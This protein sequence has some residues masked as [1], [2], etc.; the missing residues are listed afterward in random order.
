MELALMTENG[1]LVEMFVNVAEGTP[2][3]GLISAFFFRGAGARMMTRRSESEN[4]TRHVATASQSRLT[5]GPRGWNDRA[6]VAVRQ[7]S[8]SVMFCFGAVQGNRVAR[9]WLLAQ[10]GCRQGDKN[11]AATGKM[12]V[13]IK[14]QTD[15]KK[16]QIR[17]M[18]RRLS[19]VVLIHHAASTYHGG[20]GQGNW[21]RCRF[22]PTLSVQS[23]TI[24][25][26]TGRFNS[27]RCVSGSSLIQ[28]PGAGKSAAARRGKPGRERRAACLSHGVL[29][30]KITKRLP[31]KL[32]KLKVFKP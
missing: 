4:R 2:L 9:S 25:Y 23:L 14:V 19:Y 26:T 28:S 16:K 27:I 20:H 32:K 1:G 5:L 11:E 7:C 15:V 21:E 18:Q 10:G 24:L 22:Q 30:K 3:K 13:L 29:G 17:T 12:P 6:A 31:E 8:F